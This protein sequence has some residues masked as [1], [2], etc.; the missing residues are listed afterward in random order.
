MSF[1]D[2]IKS[3]LEVQTAAR[4]LCYD[5]LKK[6]PQGHLITKCRFYPSREAAQTPR[7][8]STI[9]EKNAKMVESGS[10][11]WNISVG[12]LNFPDLKHTKLVSFRQACE[13]SVIAQSIYSGFVKLAS[14]DSFFYGIKRF[15][16]ICRNK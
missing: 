12:K 10:N 2:R 9:F 5:A 7:K 15:F 1:I 4:E 6:M 16:F 8:N 3:E 14:L 13:N 11:R